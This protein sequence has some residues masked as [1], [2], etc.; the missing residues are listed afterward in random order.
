MSG[1]VSGPISTEERA[2]L[3]AQIADL[4]DVIYRVSHDLQAPLRR[5]GAFSELIMR[6]ATLDDRMTTWLTQICDDAQLAQRRLD[7]VLAYSRIGRDWVPTRVPAAEL[8]ERAVR[9]SGVDR[10]RL[11]ISAGEVGLCVDP[12]S[13]SQAIM[14]VVANAA[15]FSTQT[16]EINARLGDDAAFVIEVFDDGPGIAVR[17]RDRCRQL[18]HTTEPAAH[19]G[20]GLAVAQRVMRLHGGEVR[21]GDRDGH[22]CLVTL[23]GH[24]LVEDV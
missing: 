21:V 10:S 3:R 2:R 11:K 18:F 7:T 12:V 14:A 13:L 17:D 9:G 1:A 20:L 15:R 5:V 4:K 6:R 22:G 19:A 16:I 23:Q 24:Q 8:L